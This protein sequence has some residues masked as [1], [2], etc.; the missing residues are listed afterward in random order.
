MENKEEI[1]NLNENSSNIFNES[2]QEIAQEKGQEDT[3]HHDSSEEYVEALDEI[4]KNPIPFIG[5]IWKIIEK[6]NVYLN[7]LLLKDMEAYEIEQ[8]E[9]LEKKSKNDYDFSNFQIPAITNYSNWSRLLMDFLF[10]TYNINVKGINLK[11]KK[12][13]F[14]F[15]LFILLKKKKKKNFL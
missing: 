12:L 6:N 4:K 13:I 14:F 2:K 11:K 5:L 10:K 8:K 15:F 3:Q 9:I 1:I 7:T